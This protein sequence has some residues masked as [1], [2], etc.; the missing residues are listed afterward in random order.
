MK[1]SNSIFLKTTCSIALLA[2]FASPTLADSKV[3]I[4]MGGENNI[5]IVEQNDGSIIGQIDDVVAVHGL[6]ATPDGKF[7]IAG[8]NDQRTLGEE[9][10]DRPAGVSEADHAIHHPNQGGGANSMSAGNQQSDVISTVSVIS[11]KDNSIVRLI[12]VPGAVHHVAV[13]PDG[14]YAAVTLVIEGAISIIDLATYE[15]VT[16]L[17]TGDL[18]N[19]AIFSEDSK[20]LYVTNAGNDTISVVNIDRFIVERNIISG[21]GPEHAALSSDGKTLYVGDVTSGMASFI[22]LAT[23]EITKSIDVGDQPHGVAISDDGKTLFV[24][25]RGTN[26]LISIDIE[27]GNKQV[28]SFDTPYHITNI[29]GSGN[30]YV[31]SADAPTVWVVDQ[32]T[33]EIVSEIA[34]GARAHQ[35]VVVDAD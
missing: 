9:A 2:A 10:P 29:A 23:G 18:P 4:P 20:K 13:S 17:A 25:G 11:T 3:Y 30:L 6:A 19:Y 8:S 33:L 21:E 28:K 31:S 12:D 26:S 14:K 22:S 5:I 24:A 7:L 34:V 1:I 15:V 35:M 32:K 27:T 16:T